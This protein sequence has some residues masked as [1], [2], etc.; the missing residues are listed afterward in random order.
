MPAAQPT[1]IVIS[2]PPFPGDTIAEL[3]LGIQR[4]GGGW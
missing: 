1:M 2:K 4:E 3:D